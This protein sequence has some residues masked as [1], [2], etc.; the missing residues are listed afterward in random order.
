LSSPRGAHGLSGG[1]LASRSSSPPRLPIT[2]AAGRTSIN[3]P[4]RPDRVLIVARTTAP[5]LS[6]GRHL[7]FASRRTRRDARL[8]ADAVASFIA[9]T[10]RRRSVLLESIGRPSLFVHLWSLAIASSSTV[11]ADRVGL[12]LVAGRRVAW[13]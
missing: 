11:L 4:D 13:C 3:R 2:G 1:F 12:G 7:A 6:S 9:G 8:R 5:A 10:D